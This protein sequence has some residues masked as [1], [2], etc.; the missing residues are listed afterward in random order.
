MNEVFKKAS[1]L[2][3]GAVIGGGAIYLI[4]PGMSSGPDTAASDE[5][6]PLYWVAPMDPNYRRDQPGKSPMGMDLIP[7]YEEGSS[8]GPDAGPGTISISPEV[9]NNL[10]VRTAQAQLKPLNFA[11]STVGYVQYNQ[12]EIVHIHPRVEGWIERLHV[13]AAGEKVTRGQPLYELYSP[14]L[15][16]AQEELLFGL[17]R[18][19]ARLTA[20]AEARL[21][22]LNVSGG[23]IERLKRE[24][25]PMQT[26]TFYAPANGVVDD[27]AVREGFFI[28]P[29]MTL[30]SI[31]A[32]D[33]VWVEAE[34]FE[35]QASMIEEGLPVTMRLDYLPGR[36]WEG[37][38]D[39]VYPTL[40]EQTRTLRVRMRFPNQDHALKPN[41]FAEVSIHNESNEAVLAIPREAVI[42]G[43]QSDRV[44][45]ALGEGRFKSVAVTTGRADSA[46]MEI[47][48]GLKAGEAVVTSAQFL[49]DSESSKTSDFKRMHMDDASSE[50]AQSPEAAQPAEKPASVW[51][52]ATV[53]TVMP[54]ELKLNVNHAAIPEWG[55]PQMQMDFTVYE[56]VDLE[57]LEP[58]R[59]VQIEILRLDE[60][61]Y[62]IN[63][64]Y[65][66][67]EQ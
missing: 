6:T 56:W 46:H 11:V 60:G 21:R 5:P 49:L 32:L 7:V 65:P 14:A 30:M 57:Q 29:G 52:K 48:E 15:V 67:A 53:N 1:V 2:L 50:S 13:Q 43:G 62:R 45:L 12:D 51:A 17:N 39:Y 31:G 55:W 16:N 25:K 18:G 64:V 61:G 27:F 9:V 47:L 63:D 40:D 41:M 26:V 59:E 3:V 36:E 22:S 37:R 8:T 23:T 24:R 4:Q 28:K 20:A 33:E 35:R 34:V 44:V 19:D 38:V 42:R 54:D 66:T 10:G 58:G